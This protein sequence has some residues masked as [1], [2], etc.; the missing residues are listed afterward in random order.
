MV[1][2]ITLLYSVLEVSINLFNIYHLHYKDKFCNL[3]QSFVF[4]VDYLDSL[5]SLHYLL[6]ALTCI[7]KQ[8]LVTKK[9]NC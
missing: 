7:A 8:G 9:N 1:K 2:V 5:Y 3:T 4:S 6:A